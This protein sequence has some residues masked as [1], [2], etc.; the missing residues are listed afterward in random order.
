MIFNNLNFA[1]YYLFVQL[2]SIYIIN[3]NAIKIIVQ[4]SICLQFILL[5]ES[6]RNITI[7][8]VLHVSKFVID[9]FS[10]FQIIQIDCSILFDDIEYTITKK[11]VI[12]FV[13]HFFFVRN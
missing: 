6:A 8:N 4:N 13:L 3:E 11:N 7:R 10:I 1:K 12:D 9:L 5:N 2:I